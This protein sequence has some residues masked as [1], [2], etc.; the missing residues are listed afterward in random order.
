MIYS[1]DLI[2]Q[3]LSLFDPIVQ[4]Q[5]LPRPAIIVPFEEQVDPTDCWNSLLPGARETS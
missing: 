5:D 4:L 1:I 2:M 3:L